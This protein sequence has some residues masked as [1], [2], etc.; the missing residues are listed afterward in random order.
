MRACASHT[1]AYSYKISEKLL[2]TGRNIK[3]RANLFFFFY[4]SHNE[5]YEDAYIYK[6]YKLNV[7]LLT[8]AAAP[9]PSYD[10]HSTQA[11]NQCSK[12]TYLIVAL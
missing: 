1:I 11:H 2:T 5:H 6:S 12:S 3:T 8:T 7:K 10:F 9:S 4:K